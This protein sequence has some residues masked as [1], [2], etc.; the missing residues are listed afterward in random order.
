MFH[1]CSHAWE[2]RGLEDGTLVRL[3]QRDLNAETMTQ[4]VDDLFEVVQE[5]GRPNLSLDFAEV[6][7][8]AS[9]TV[10]KL[11]ALNTRLQEHGGRLTLM[12]LEP[13]M[14]QTLQAVNL[15]DVFDIHAKSTVTSVL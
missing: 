1:F 9:V 13:V 3:T 11:M 14:V 5:S 7:I 12:N 6:R 15:T 10:G 2:V 4:L 8:L